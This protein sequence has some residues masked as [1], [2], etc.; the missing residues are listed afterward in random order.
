[1]ITKDIFVLLVGACFVAYCAGWLA[2]EWTFH[3]EFVRRVSEQ[4]HPPVADDGEPVAPY[5]ADNVNDGKKTSPA[6]LQE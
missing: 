2:A 3:K 6:H 4:L 1:M 5:A